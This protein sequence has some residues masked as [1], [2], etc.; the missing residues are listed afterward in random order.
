RNATRCLA[1]SDARR[2]PDRW[3]RYTLP[4][5]AFAGR[6][7]S[8]LQSAAT[9]PTSSTIRFEGCG[10]GLCVPNG[11]RAAGPA[12]VANTPISWLCR[13]PTVLLRAA[14]EQEEI[15]PLFAYLRKSVNSQQLAPDVIW[16]RRHRGRFRLQTGTPR[17][18]SAPNSTLPS[19]PCG[20]AP[21][22]GQ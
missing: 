2:R 16:K 14:G 15:R 4:T 22:G 18:R 19:A 8:V 20:W 12:S 3:A 21:F 9:T 5:T 10:S 7:R 17:F 11:I 13:W 6:A 1:T